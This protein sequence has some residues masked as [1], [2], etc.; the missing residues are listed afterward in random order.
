[1]SDN[2]RR[3][4][5]LEAAMAV[6]AEQGYDRASINKIAKAAGV[7]SPA[8]IYWYFKD[9]AELFSTVITEMSPLR[10]LPVNDP[11]VAAQIMDLPPHEVLPTIAGRI[12]GFEED[13]QMAAMMR[14]YMGE[15]MRSPEAAEAVSRFQKAMVSFLE[16][17][18]ARQVELGRLRP[19]D[20]ASSARML[21]GTMVIYLLGRQ[22][23]TEM[24][25]GFPP[26]E[27]YI[28][29]VMDVLLHGL[30]QSDDE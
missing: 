3:Q 15:A 1:M 18:L 12:S 11:E 21:I 22:V 30:E 2:E 10:E 4:Q 5:I 23:F 6:F 19:H 26:R 28:A 9:K 29:G 13:P 27:A 17:Y 25:P 24:A 14:L 16:Q 7:K 20:T 8:L